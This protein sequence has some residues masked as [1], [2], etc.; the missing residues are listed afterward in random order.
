MLGTV[1]FRQ[2]GLPEFPECPLSPGTGREPLGGRHVGVS[3]VEP[4]GVGAAQVDV[5][6][7]VEVSDRS[8]SG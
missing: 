6:L 3:G 1:Q 5:K 8:G 7:S 2:G 4:G